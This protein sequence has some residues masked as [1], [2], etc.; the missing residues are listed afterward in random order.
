MGLCRAEP[1]KLPG[2]LGARCDLSLEPLVTGSPS[3]LPRF[4]TTTVPGNSQT[5]AESMADFSKSS[6]FK[7][8]Y[9]WRQS[10]YCSIL[11]LHLLATRERGEVP[12]NFAH[13]QL[14]PPV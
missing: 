12:V 5:R 14:S 2:G 13:L 6:F 3:H 10:S 11:K 9:H 4:P 8:P 7:S 1:V